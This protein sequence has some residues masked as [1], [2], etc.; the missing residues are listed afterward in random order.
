MNNLETESEGLAISIIHKDFNLN[1]LFNYVLE[2]I[3][4]SIS[5]RIDFKIDLK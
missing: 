4:F 3:C 2:N 1:N 5:S